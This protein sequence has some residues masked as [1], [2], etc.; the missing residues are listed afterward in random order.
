MYDGDAVFVTDREGSYAAPSDGFR[1]DPGDVVVGGPMGNT[2][3]ADAIGSAYPDAGYSNIAIGGAAMRFTDSGLSKL[4][5]PMPAQ[6]MWAQALDDGA[7]ER[8]DGAVKAFVD[9]GEDDLG[10]SEVDLG[11]QRY[12]A[13]DLLRGI[14][15]IR[16]T[17]LSNV[18]DTTL[19]TV[20]CG[21]ICGYAS[22]SGTMPEF[23]EC[24]T[25]MRLSQA[26]Y[27]QH[28]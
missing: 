5:I 19:K 2:E 14:R 22:F 18:N 8:I 24:V 26:I 9:Y 16:E 17:I 3:L 25:P 21:R 10:D 7:R 1:Y 20:V 4:K 28:K 13:S 15:T 23:V 12:R 27:S 11:G 6:A